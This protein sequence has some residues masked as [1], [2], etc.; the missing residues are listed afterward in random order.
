[1]NILGI[2]G[3]GRHTSVCLLCDGKLVA[4]VE[5]ERFTRYKGDDRAFP[6][7]AIQYCMVQGNV[8]LAQIDRIAFGWDAT[9]YPWQMLRFLGAN[10]IKYRSPTAPQ[11]PARSDGFGG[12]AILRALDSVMAYTPATLTTKISLGLRAAGFKDPIPPVE[13]VNHHLAHAYS[14]YFCSP[15]N[16]AGILTLDGS[17]EDVCTQL[18][19]GEGDDVRVVESVPVPHSLGW[20]Y[21]AIT[22]YL[23]FT[24]DMDEGKLMG[25]AA[26]GEARRQN[27]KWVDV[28][29]KVIRTGKG[30]YEVDPQYTKLGGHSYGSHFSDQLVDLLTSV[31]PLAVP[32]GLGEKAEI[33]GRLQGKYLADM[34]VDIAWAAQHLLEQAGIMLARKLVDEYQVKHLCLAGGV[35]L[36]CKMNGEILQNSGCEE[37]FVQPAASD[38]GVA[39]GAALYVAK[40]LGEDIRNPLVHSYFGPEFSNDEIRQALE[41]AKLSYEKTND[42]AK[43]AVDFLERGKIVAWF[44]GRMEFGPRALGNRSILA[45]PVTSCIHN[46]VNE[47]VKYRESWRPFCPSLTV[48]SKQRYLE[49]AK[50]SPFMIVAFTMPEEVRSDLRSVVHVDGT[51]RPQTVTPESNPLYHE[52][53]S[54]LGKRTGHPIV[55]NT[56]FNV[57]GEP[58]VCSP[59]DA[60]RCFYSS[61][62]DALVMGDFVLKKK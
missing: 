53:I 60:T 1:L 40:Q 5:S 61:G 11:R 19:I 58:V 46:A 34:Y 13:F 48:E 35:A 12:S 27:N 22:Q 4:F 18:S 57:R 6:I 28:L 41:N 49:K 33:D 3:F 52:L 62:L 14:T 16:K 9:K 37:V 10:Y 38:D 26:Y 50:F 7:R 24:P 47:Q 20:F 21:A 59:L 44:Q 54:G 39:L 36:N 32:I 42:P 45:N 30:S 17:G 25:L 15:F 23:G 8:T 29:S 31:D 56:S 2:N 55:L 43:T 51:I